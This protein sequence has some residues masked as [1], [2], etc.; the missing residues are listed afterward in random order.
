MAHRIGKHEDIGKALARLVT[1]DLLA[2]RHGLSGDGPPAE[3]IHRVRQ[4]LKRLRSI[5]KV[6]R[7]VLGRVAVDSAA[8]LRDAA[9]LLADARDTDAATAS[10]RSLREVAEDESTGL[11]RVIATLE[12]ESFSHHA[13][14]TPIAPVDAL[15]AAAERSLAEAPDNVD[16]EVLLRQAID[17]AYRRGRTAMQRATF[18]LATPDLHQ[19]R[20][21]VKDLWHLVQLA[22]KRLPPGARPMASRLKRLGDVL[23]LDHD[24]AMLAERLAL[25]PTGDPALMQQLSLI[26]KQR[27][28]LEGRAF[29]LGARI[30]KAKP[31]TFRRRMRLK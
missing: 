24:H 29:A 2:A 3:R 28:V 26:A 17:R 9:R 30:Y 6:L 27:R 13:E 1:A 4:R 23:G 21:S 12:R 10:A 8:T 15:L 11:D 14:A 7:P 5:L 20:K 22:R 25:S 19:W 31:K 18:S 16:G